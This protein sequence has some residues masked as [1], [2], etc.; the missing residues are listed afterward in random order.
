MTRENMQR[1]PNRVFTVAETAEIL[2]CSEGFVRR[3]LTCGLMRYMKI[4]DIKIRS[5]ALDEFLERFDGE[6]VTKIL[7]RME[8]R[9]E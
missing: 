8:A 7:K 3:I 9:N 6:D 1:L 2:R 5:E 4:G